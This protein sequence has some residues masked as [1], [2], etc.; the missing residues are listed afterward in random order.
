MDKENRRVRLNVEAR[1][2]L[3]WWF[4]FGLDWNGTAMM[5]SLVAEL[6]P[7]CLTHGIGSTGMEYHAKG[8]AADCR[9]GYSVGRRMEWPH[10]E[11][12]VR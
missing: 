12:Q 7:W 8:T 9:G 1:A 11:G 4:Q 6:V 5:K 3:E 10:S 2:D